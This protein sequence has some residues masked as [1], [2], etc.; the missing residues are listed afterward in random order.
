[1]NKMIAALSVVLIFS[2][3]ASPAYAYCRAPGA[4]PEAPRSYDKPKQPNCMR[5]ARYGEKPDCDQYELDRY[6]READRYLQKLQEY[7]EE[8]QGYAKEAA[9]YAQCEAA[10]MRETLN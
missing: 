3:A 1:M 9:A 6:R 7:A 10:E 5:N 2:F 4:A 8:A